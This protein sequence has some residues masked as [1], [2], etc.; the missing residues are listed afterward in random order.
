MHFENYRQVFAALKDYRKCRLCIAAAAEDTV[1]QAVRE[2]RKE[3]L[4]DFVLVGNE[5][6]IWRLAIAN[7]LNLK[8]I[9]IIDIKDPVEAVHRAVQEVAAGR[10]EIL[11]K[12]MVNS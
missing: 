10:A 2:A 3:D 11:M 7:S 9:D 1:L 5:E 8:G 6:Q 4:V 12:G